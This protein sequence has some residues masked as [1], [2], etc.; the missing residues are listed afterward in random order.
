MVLASHRLTSAPLPWG[1]IGARTLARV[2][3][4]LNLLVTEEWSAGGRIF[5]TLRKSRHR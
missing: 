5:V 4:S 1:R 2:A 3:S